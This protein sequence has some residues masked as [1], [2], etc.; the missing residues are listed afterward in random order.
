MST[1]QI[2]IM[3]PRPAGSEKTC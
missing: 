2:I 1:D 3:M